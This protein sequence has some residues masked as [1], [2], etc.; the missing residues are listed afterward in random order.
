MGLLCMLILTQVADALEPI[1]KKHDIPAMGGA[2]VTSQGVV[3]IGVTGVRKA[4]TDEAVKE[5]DRWH[6]G[7][8]TKAMTATMI[9]TLVEEGK[10]RW[11]DTVGAAFPE[12]EMSAALKRVTLLHLLSHRS[13]LPAN[14]PWHELKERR[15]AV[16]RAGGLKLPEDPRYEYSN[17]GYVIA[18]AMTEKATG[19]TWEE[20]MTEKLFKPLG[21]KS[22]GFGGQTSWGHTA[23][24]KP[25]DPKA[26]NPPILGPAGTVHASLSDWGKF[27]ADQLKMG[28]L[29]PE[30]YKKM[31]QPAFGGDYAL[32][33]LVA[34]RDWGG[35]VYTH[36][37]CNTM[38]YAVVWMSPEKNFA[39]LVVCNQGDDQAAKACDEAAGA[40]IRLHK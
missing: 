29:K 31:R 26:D 21:M 9:A 39:V 34:R 25:A 2:I 12:I 8:D 10:L 36:A 4:G 7:S 20:L 22:A 40:L 13:G 35:T 5:D 23:G 14:L 27:V 17:L 32:G 6:L 3:A 38:N 15:K 37:G 16:V 18:G 24:G 33:W 1:R 11:D 19:K 30:T 28:L